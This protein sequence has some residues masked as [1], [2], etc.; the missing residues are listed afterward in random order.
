MEVGEGEGRK[1]AMRE[2]GGDW[3]RPDNGRLDDV[4]RHRL[5]HHVQDVVEHRVELNELVRRQ[6]ARVEDGAVPPP[7]LGPLWEAACTYSSHLG[8][9]CRVQVA[10][11][12][13][14]GADLFCNIIYVIKNIFDY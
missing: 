14:Q 2:V 3:S 11:C 8:A 10:G 13:V 1:K 12:R 6:S 5:A 9:V 4:F 7:E